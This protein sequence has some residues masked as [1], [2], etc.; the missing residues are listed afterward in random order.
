MTQMLQYAR[1]QHNTYRGAPFSCA[2]RADDEFAAVHWQIT[3]F[4]TQVVCIAADYCRLYT[5]GW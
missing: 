3:Q 1:Q 2:A 5:G 4:E